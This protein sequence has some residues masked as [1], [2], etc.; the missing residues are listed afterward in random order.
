MI[1]LEPAGGGVILPIQ[2]Q[3]KAGRNG[4]RGQYDISL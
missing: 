3:P 4:T 2:A 1:D